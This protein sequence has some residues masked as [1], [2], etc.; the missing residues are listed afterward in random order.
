MPYDALTMKDW[1]IS[2]AAEKKYPVM[3]NGG[4]N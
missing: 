4:K 3:I 1:Q 2:E